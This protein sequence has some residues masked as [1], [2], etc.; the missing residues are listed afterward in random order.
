M[1][2]DLDFALKTL[3]KDLFEVKSTLEAGGTGHKSLG[4]RRYSR[5]RR[6][7]FPE[8]PADHGRMSVELE[9]SDIASCMM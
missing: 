9:M 7:S 6:T 5:S 2:Q 1:K 4:S 8:M 3:E